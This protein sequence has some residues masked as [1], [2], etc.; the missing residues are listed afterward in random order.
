MATFQRKHIA[1]IESALLR[2]YYFK[3]NCAL[4]LSMNEEVPDE[5]YDAS[6]SP[7]FFDTLVQHIEDR[8]FFSMTPTGRI[9]S[10]HPGVEKVLGYPKDEWIGQ[11]FSIIFTEEDQA[12]GAP[13][14]EMTTAERNGHA[15]DIRWHVRKDGSRLFVDGVLT[16]ARNDAGKTI[17]FGKVMRDATDRHLANENLNAAL[18]YVRSIVDTVREPMLVLDQSLRVQSASRSFYEAF[19][20]TAEE[21]EQHFLYELSEGQWN[22]PELRRSL[23]EALFEKKV[24]EDFEV[25]RVFPRVGTKVMLLNARRVER[26]SSGDNLILLAFEDITTRRRTEAALRKSET[27]FLAAFANAP[28]GM[29][30][31][32][33]TGSILEANPAFERMVGYT[34]AELIGVDSKGITH[35]DDVTKT[36]AFLEECQRTR[37]STEFEKRYIARDG[38]VLWARVSAVLQKDEADGSAAQLIAIVEDVTTRKAAEDALLESEEQLRLATEASKLGTWDINPATGAWRMSN[39]SKELIGIGANEPLA[40]GHALQLVDK[41][42]RVRNMEELRLALDPA[43]SGRYNAEFR[44]AKQQDGQV[45]WLRSTGQAY[46]ESGRPVRFIGTLEDISERKA[47]EERLQKSEERLSLAIEASSLIGTWDWDV[48]ANKI[49]ADTRFAM[50]FSVDPEKAAA[51]TGLEEFTAAIHPEDLANGVMD[52][53]KRVVSRGGEFAEQYRLIQ[54]DGTVR[55]MLARGRAYQDETGRVVRFAGVGVDQT[56]GREAAE[57]LQDTETRLKLA[58]RA[59]QIGIWEYNPGTDTL[60]F[61]SW[62]MQI[63]GLAADAEITWNETFLG[64]VHPSDR[65]RVKQ[66]L[67]SVVDGECFGDFAIEYQIVERSASAERRVVIHGTRVEHSNGSCRLVGTV[68]DITEDYKAAQS[69]RESQERMS[70]ALEASYAFGVWDWDIRNDRFRADTRLA[71]IFGLTAQQAE[72]GVPLSQA[73]AN[74]HPDDASRVIEQIQVAVATGEKYREEYRLVQPDGSHRWVSVRGHVQKDAEGNPMRFPGVGL[75]ITAEREALNALLQSNEELQAFA[76]A[77]SHDLQEPLRT[78]ATFAQL[79]ARRYEGELQGDADLYIRYIVD[80]AKRMQALVA[81]VLSFTKAGRMEGLPLQAVDMQELCVA[82][83]DYLRTAIDES[84][85][86]VHIEGLPTVQANAQQL[87][88]VLQ[89]LI[90]NAL[91]Y[92]RPGVVPYISVTAQRAKNE[93]IICVADNGLGFAQEQSKQ[94]FEVFRRLHGREIPGTGVGLALCK[95][96]VERYGGRIWAESVPFEGSTFFFSLPA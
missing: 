88:Q 31:S 77:A 1:R 37:S 61:D 70:L 6:G 24:V 20:V 47:V 15:A 96:I 46:F 10:W 39:R 75:D 80:G 51:G 11:P 49:Y 73:A 82:V 36:R 14:K 63:A 86:V 25:E 48:P 81:S 91:K 52:S 57:A 67:R 87:D 95:R 35:P 55:W 43:G 13:L 29:V 45:R 3:T 27:R 16:C 85:A 68:R 78:V 60:R 79:L 18:E 7:G 54:K 71:A 74:L 66:T 12:L 93:W 72:K 94:I 4:Y 56:A 84:G 89:N 2:K 40:S 30:L 28:V 17:G 62:A 83:L 42:D 92:H 22:I 41:R 23:K 53:I 26:Q 76:Y 64:L 8:A 19:Q 58:L 9:N 34:A 33:P 59:A 44:L 69:L 65:E 38:R 90:G 32:T 5:Q 21:T 50:L